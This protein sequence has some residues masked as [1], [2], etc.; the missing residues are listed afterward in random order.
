MEAIY[1]LLIALLLC[2]FFTAVAVLKLCYSIHLEL[3]R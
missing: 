1:F 2:S 3:K